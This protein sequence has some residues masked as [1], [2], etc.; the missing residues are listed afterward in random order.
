MTAFLAGPLAVLIAVGRPRSRRAWAWLAAL[1]FWL[2]L[3][4]A[5]PGTLL[6]ELV[7][8]AAVVSSGVG[9]LFLLLGRG[10]TS[11]RA[12]QG[13][14]AA[15][16]GTT[17][18]AA[19]HGVHWADVE[20]AVVQQ[21]LTAQRVLSDLLTQGSATP[22]PE[23]YAAIQALS[24]GIRPM[25]PFF[26]G[27]LALLV[28]SGL[29]LAA[30]VAPRITGRAAVPVP[31]RFNGFR[32]SDHLV[33]LVVVGLLGVLFAAGTPVYGPAASLLA[34][35]AGLYLIRGLAVLATA[36]RAAPPLFVALLMGCA[37]FLLPFA[38]GGL[39]LLGLADNWLDFRRR[40]PPPTLGG[41]DR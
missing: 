13:T 1:V 14:L 17:I 29:C 35:G 20:F 15:V 9:V 38:L 4:A 37:V 28:L 7:R 21:G 24:E 10:S 6:E 25:A 27:V 12:L 23:L 16:V 31:G 3:W 19:V 2:A 36:L 5:Q 33:W 30:L 34:F 18:L 8:A 39:T 11:A 26:P 41:T 32:F 22:S 40:I